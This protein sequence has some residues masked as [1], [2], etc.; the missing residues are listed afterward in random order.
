MRGL[1]PSSS[2]DL[3]A[4]GP[5]PVCKRPA[6]A[7]SVRPSARG[8]PAEYCG[9]AC[10]QLFN[11]EKEHLKLELARVLRQCALYGIDPP[12]ADATDA[13]ELALSQFT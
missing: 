12:P 13:H 7:N 4:P 3:L 10:R 11:R 8:R 1:E 2:P 9:A 5:A 6:C